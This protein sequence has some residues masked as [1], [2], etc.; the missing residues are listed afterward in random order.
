MSTCEQRKSDTLL[1]SDSYHYFA[2][3]SM[4]LPFLN[5]FDG[6]KFKRDFVEVNALFK[7]DRYQFLYTTL[8][9]SSWIA[10]KKNKLF[11][12]IIKI[13]YYSHSSVHHCSQLYVNNNNNFVCFCTVY[14]LCINNSNYLAINQ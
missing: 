9:F 2:S 4:C 7:L 13:L 1:I 14:T 3:C 5:H 8:P 11:L 10:N 12:V 6:L